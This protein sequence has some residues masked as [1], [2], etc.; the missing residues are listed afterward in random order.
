[1]A[2]SKEK[3]TKALKVQKE[4]EIKALK[5]YNETWVKM[6]KVLEVGT[7]LS[8]SL[9]SANQ[10]AGQGFQSLVG[11]VK[12]KAEAENEKGEREID[13]R[14]SIMGRS[15]DIRLPTPSSKAFRFAVAKILDGNS[16]IPTMFP[17]E[18]VHGTNA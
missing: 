17:Q 5:D 14:C 9:R 10:A 18:A 3:D 11:Q 13:V 8:F 2:S 6:I 16:G 1:M 7:K 15:D 12:S 4:K